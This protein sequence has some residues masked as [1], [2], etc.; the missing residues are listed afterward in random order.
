MQSNWMEFVGTMGI[1][2]LSSLILE[3]S[4]FLFIERNYSEGHMDPVNIFM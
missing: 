1:H 2:S 3:E 4:L